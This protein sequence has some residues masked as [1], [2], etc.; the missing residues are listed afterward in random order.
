MEKSTSIEKIL[1]ALQERAKEL[2]CLYKVEELLNDS[3]KDN[4]YI[5]SS[6]VRILP[7]GWQYP[8][9][10]VSKLII[11]DKIYCSPNFMETEWV[12]KA[13]IVVQGTVAGSLQVY[14]T[15]EKPALD[16]G[17]FLKRRE[18]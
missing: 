14:Y 1:S 12:Q 7:P 6:I 18:S 2:N 15:E 16:E 5:F 3:E 11:N 8:D 17:P 4:E 13:E 9:L 10:C